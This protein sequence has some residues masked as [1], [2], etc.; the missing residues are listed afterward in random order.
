MRESSINAEISVRRRIIS[1]ASIRLLSRA[2]IAA[3]FRG[4]TIYR[5]RLSELTKSF[6]ACGGFK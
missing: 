4:A 6:T 5:E 1:D 2:E 3:L